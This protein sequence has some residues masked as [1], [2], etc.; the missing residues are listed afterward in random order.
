M[1]TESLIQLLELSVG[2]ALLALFIRY[3]WQSILVDMTRQRLF[4][5]R[6]SIFLYAADGRIDFDSKTYGELRDRLNSAI[7]F[8]HKAKFSTVFAAIAVQSEGTEAPRQDRS[9]FDVISEIEDA[10][11]R[12]DLEEKV[13]EAVTF[14]TTLMILRSPLLLLLSMMLLP[15]MLIIE[16]LSGHIKRLIEKIG[17]IIERDI[18]FESH[19]WA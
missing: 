10:E 8:C 11:L 5:V 13:I 6:D 2:I 19:K 1:T 16:L 17:T 14:L 15:F 18:S 9:L 4:E 12:N 7:R 3:P